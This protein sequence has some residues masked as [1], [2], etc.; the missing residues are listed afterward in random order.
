APW[1]TAAGRSDVQEQ[2]KPEVLRGPPE[3]VVDRVPIRPLGQRRDGNERPDQPELRAAL[4]LL[5][6]VVDVVDV[7]HGDALEAIGI[8]LAELRDP[9]VVHTTDGGEQPAVRDAV[10]EEPLARLQAR[11]P[12]SVHLVLFDHRLGIVAPEPDV[13]P[14]PEE[15]DLRRV[16]E[17]LSCLNHRAQGADLLA[18]DEPRVVLATGGG[19]HPFHPG[20]AVLESRLDPLRVQVRR[21]DDVGVCRDELICRHRPV[22]AESKHPHVS[23]RSPSTRWAPY[24]RSRALSKRRLPCLRPPQSARGGRRRWNPVACSKAWASWSTPHSS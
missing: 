9:V 8:G 21:L 24:R 11:A 15:I 4:E 22:L 3:P 23:R 7:E 17:P 5:T 20:R 12:D 18:V 19:L 2:W 14:Y 1:D 6:G 16:L 10:P 13:F